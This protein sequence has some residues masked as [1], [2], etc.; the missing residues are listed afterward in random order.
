[1]AYSLSEMLKE[2]AYI[3]KYIARLSRTLTKDDAKK[4]SDTYLNHFSSYL[5]GK[6]GLLNY[7]QPPK[8]DV[9][10]FWKEF[11]KA[12][13]VKIKRESLNRLI[14][15]EGVKFLPMSFSIIN[16][17]IDG[18]H[19]NNNTGAEMELRRIYDFIRSTDR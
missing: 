12:T 16:Q 1:M 3:A 19:N 17:L 15:G 10:V 18:L 13:P 5:G 6:N 9:E 8:T 14:D 11:D 4:I 2:R 7:A